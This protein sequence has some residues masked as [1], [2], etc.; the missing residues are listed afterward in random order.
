[1]IETKKYFN[2]FKLHTQY[3]ICE[4]AIKIE[5]LEKYCK[6]NK[7]KSIGIPILFFRFLIR[8]L[9]FLKFIFFCRK[10][11]GPTKSS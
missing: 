11:N 5:D 9:K 6:N 10:I 4:G 7:I 8:I 3:S 2:H 1:M